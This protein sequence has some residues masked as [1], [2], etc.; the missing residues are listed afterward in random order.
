MFGRVLKSLLFVI[1]FFSVA[2]F[3][4]TQTDGFA[5]TKITPSFIPLSWPAH[6]PA[7]KTRS[8]LHQPFTYLGKG[9]Q[10]FVF[11]SAD[12]EYV[13]KFIRQDHWGHRKKKK[14]SRLTRDFTS[15]QIAY[16]HLRDET[17]LLYLHLSPTDFLH[18]KIT[19]IDRLGIHHVLDLDQYEFIVQRKAA[20]IYPTLEK[21]IAEKKIEEAKEALSSLVHLLDLRLQ[22]GIFDKDSDL[23]TNFGFL[24]TQAMQIDIGRFRT[25]SHP[26]DKA[27]IVRIT[28]HLH[29]WLMVQ[30]PELDIHLR[31]VIDAV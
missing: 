10:S 4:K 12:G 31:S 19:I 18:E 9:V 6:L 22:K 11:A 29:Q 17:G 1:G 21:W 25:P 28:D 23:N 5:I 14:Q 8:I 27:E 24:G 7:E 16:D 20:L 2:R 26:L 13:I 3:C 30:S 15:Y